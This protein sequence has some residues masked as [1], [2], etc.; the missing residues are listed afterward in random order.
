MKKIEKTRLVV[1][2]GGMAGTACVEEI[3]K[4]GG[5]DRFDMTVIGSEPHPNYNRVLL[6][7]VLTGEK[8]VSDI[9]THGRDWYENNGVR[10]VTG[11]EVTELK[12]ASRCVAADGKALADYDKLIIAT[13]AL[14]IMPR[15]QGI[16]LAGVFTFRDVADCERMR[17]SRDYNKFI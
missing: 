17:A 9:T 6:S 13:G 12:R 16:D 4:T 10:L 7:H 1:V 11:L 8:S 3:I 14:P 15:I 5:R 2:G